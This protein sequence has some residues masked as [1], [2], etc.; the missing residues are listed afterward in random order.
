MKNLLIILVFITTTLSASDL[1]DFLENKVND[2]K[3]FYE[4]YFGEL[5]D[6]KLPKNEIS[7]TL[8]IFTS[9]SVP[10]STIRNYIKASKNLTDIKTY[11]VYRGMDK[12]MLQTLKIISSK[13]DKFLV[14]VHPMMFSDLNITKVPSLVYAQCPDKFRYKECQ[15]LYRMDGD[16]SIESFFR[17]IAE[18]SK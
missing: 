7:P 6:D 8:L 18:K 10:Q 2:S 3:L 4:Q 11:L 1:D 16:M 17:K 9:K 12:D 15:Y 5:V 13:K 14:K